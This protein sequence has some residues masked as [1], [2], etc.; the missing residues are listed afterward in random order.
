MNGIADLEIASRN[1]GVG[2]KCGVHP[3]VNIEKE[4]Q[5][6]ME[7]FGF[8]SY[9]HHNSGS[10]IAVQT[11]GGCLNFAHDL[12]RQRRT[13][14]VIRSG[15]VSDLISTPSLGLDVILLTGR[16][17]I[18]LSQHRLDS[19]IHARCQVY[20]FGAPSKSRYPS[21]KWNCGYVASTRTVTSLKFQ[22]KFAL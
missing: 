6:P 10:R 1:Y 17:I 20:S 8:L 9:H 2:R 21:H 7:Y 22:P 11:D 12:K 4:G 19:T 5:R 18:N 14:Y 13:V 16:T 15:F 3:G